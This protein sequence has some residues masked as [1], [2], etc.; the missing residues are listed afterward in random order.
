MSLIQEPNIPFPNVDLAVRI[1]DL[2]LYPRSVN[3]NATNPISFEEIIIDEDMFAESIFGSVSYW[4]TSPNMELT[5]QIQLAGNISQVVIT[6]RDQTT[7]LFGT[8]YFDIVDITVATDLADKS[9]SAGPVNNPSGEGARPTKIVVRFASNIFLYGNFQNLPGTDWIGKIS[10]TGSGSD[11]YEVPELPRAPTDNS[12]G[13]MQ[14]VIAPLLNKPLYADNTYNDIWY[15]H[16][17][18]LYPWSKIGSGVRI[19]QLVNYIC[20]YACFSGNKNAVNFFFWEDLYGWNFKSIE[21]L[22]QQTAAQ[23]YIMS[24]DENRA[25]A[26]VS[27]EV[28]N[29]V[30]PTKLFDAGAFFSEYIRVKP[31][32]STVYESVGDTNLNI[33]KQK[34]VYD[35]SVSPWRSI[36]NSRLIDFAPGSVYSSTVRLTD[37]N[38]GFYQTT[39]SDSNSPWWNYYDNYNSYA[40]DNTEIEPDRLQNKY[41]KS[42]F[43]F[44][45]L[46]AAWLKVIYKNI[47]WPLNENRKAYATAKRGKEMWN[48][49]KDSGCCVRSAPE[50]FFAVL[51]GAKKIYGS[52]GKGG[53]D[54]VI[55]DSSGIWAYDWVEVEFW[56]REE[57]SEVL[58]NE[59]YQ[60]IEFEDNSFPFIFVRPK[61]AAYGTAS[62][63]AGFA[64]T[65]AFNL[66]EILN[67][68]I[69][70]THEA[71]GAEGNPDSPFT[72][73]S[74]P[75]ITDTL[76]LNTEDEELRKEYTSYPKNFSMMPVG[77]FR[78]IDKEGGCPPD[79]EDGGV[80][81]TASS[82]Y[83]GGRIVQ[84]YKIPRKSL[85]GMVGINDDYIN[86]LEL[87]LDTT[88]NSDI[89]Q[90]IAGKSPNTN[91]ELFR[92]PMQ[93]MFIFDTENAHDG[94][95]TDCG[96]E[97]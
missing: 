33:Q 21:T 59:F 72:L 2:V 40:N 26:I 84:M 87:L 92:S 69:P 75:G 48:L 22:T 39:Y 31:N 65:R 88:S 24:L 54:N 10:K 23:T 95:C 67:S 91:P 35:Y 70:K 50:T 55:N 78:I 9:I 93:N 85:T 34:L 82:M 96:E 28:L 63:G 12:G 29:T 60:I 8:F 77:K 68:R 27:F 47:K 36:A 52:D 3:V 30:S 43:D 66:N 1:G 42:Q 51:T 86:K 81:P 57:I 74:N 49:F 16:D 11:V 45:E 89:S 61:G 62:A 38:Y 71:N 32:W 13:F 46:P 79:W 6:I 64:D 94:I 7:S 37:T 56:P 53:S 14:E 58:E 20:E 5:N 18:A 73:M 17:H 80:D 83:F 19:S 44:C 76:G 97:T 4:D 15:K 90:L 41:W 25:N